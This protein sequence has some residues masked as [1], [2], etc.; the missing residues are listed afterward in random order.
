MY[1]RYTC[2]NGQVVEVC[3]STILN[4]LFIVFQKEDDFTTAKLHRC[5]TDYF[6]DAI[7]NG[8]LVKKESK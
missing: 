6:L 5:S 4:M 8:R 7:H 3:A 1:D 2:A